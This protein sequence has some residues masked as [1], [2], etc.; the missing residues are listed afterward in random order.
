[1]VLSATPLK[2]LQVKDGGRKNDMHT[3]KKITVRQQITA[4]TN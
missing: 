3:I 1:M 2:I 4:E